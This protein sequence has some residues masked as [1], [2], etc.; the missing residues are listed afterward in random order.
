MYAASQEK[1]PLIIY[2]VTITRDGGWGHGDVKKPHHLLLLVKDGRV[3]IKT[4]GKTYELFA[5][6]VF[7]IPKDTFY[8][9]ESEGRFLHTVI[10][11]DADIF[12][13]DGDINEERCMSG[14]FLF[15]KKVESGDALRLDIERAAETCK[16]DAVFDCERRIALMSVLLGMSRLSESRQSSLASRIRAYLV[17]HAGERITLEDICAHFSYTKQYLI[18]IFK[19]ETGKTPIAALNEIKLNRSASELLNSIDGIAEVAARCGFD[20]YNYF[21]RLFR[22][23]FGVTPSEYR[24]NN[25]LL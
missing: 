17:A 20:D 10:H 14:R 6:D 2:H 7:F 25:F 18:R 4:E 3:R 15:P 8:S 21:A 1:L 9:L 12:D 22:N 24:K 11:F 16:D 19:R 23:R 5:N 13:T